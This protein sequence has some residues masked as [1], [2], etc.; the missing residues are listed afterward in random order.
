MICANPDHLVERGDRLVWCAG[1]L[2]S[3]YEKAGG[4]AIYAGKPHAPIYML[5]LETITTLARRPVSKSEVLAIGDG[6]H[7]DIA[8]A[9]GVGIESVFIASGLHLPAASGGK[10]GGEGFEQQ[11]LEQLFTGAEPRPIGAMRA[12][13]W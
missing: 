5:A 2:A 9:A 12:L 8:G 3:L 11:A 4:S 7:T 10:A 13:L 6:L 1:A